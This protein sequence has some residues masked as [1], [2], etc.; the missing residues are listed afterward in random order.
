MTSGDNREVAPVWRVT[1]T[2]GTR[3][4]WK[5]FPSPNGQDLHLDAMQIAPDG[6]S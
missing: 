3:Q 2:T 5:E 4:L 1:W 6:R